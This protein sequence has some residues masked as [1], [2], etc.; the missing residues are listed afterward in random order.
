M[1]TIVIIE[2]SLQQGLSQHYILYGIAQRWRDAGHRIVFHY[3][4]LAPPPGDIA[5]LHVDLSVVPFEYRPFLANYRKV[6]N[7]GLLD[8]SKRAISQNLVAQDS[9]WMGSVIVKTDANAGGQPEMRLHQS[10]PHLYPM[11]PILESYPI[12]QSLADV[13]DWAWSLPGIVVE[14][15]LPEQDQKGYYMRGCTFFGSRMR[16]W[17]VRAH[18][19]LI[20]GRDF[21]EMEML[22]APPELFAWRA[23]LGMEYGKLDY[24]RHEGQYVLLDVNRTPAQPEGLNDQPARLESLR[25]LGDCLEDFL[26]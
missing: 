8:I 16:N 4:P 19:P 24:V 5:I 15:F 20:K 6:I 10:A 22:P 13:P 7:G 17:R 12:L 26:R 14:K 2:H 11:V 21:L 3:G 18:V 1:A 23:Q 25:A 9:D